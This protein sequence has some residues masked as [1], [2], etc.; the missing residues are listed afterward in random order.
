M[1]T[2]QTVKL[3]SGHSMPVIGLGTWLSK[4]GEVAAAVKHAIKS[5]Y[6]WVRTDRIGSDPEIGLSTLY[7]KKA[8]T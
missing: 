2:G 7:V 6:R 8:E 3:S 1:S 5:G 4:P